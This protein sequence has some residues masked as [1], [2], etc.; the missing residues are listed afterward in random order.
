MSAKGVLNLLG[1]SPANA[2]HTVGE[3]G[4]AQTKVLDMLEGIRDRLKVTLGGLSGRES[5]VCLVADSP[6]SY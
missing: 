6:W 1:L 5:T 4:A 3:I 2:L